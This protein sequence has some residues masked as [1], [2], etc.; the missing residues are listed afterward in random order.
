P[1]AAKAPTRP[2]RALGAPQTTC[3]GAPEPV[4]T[5]RTRSLSASGCFSA[6][7]TLAMTKGFSAALS[8]TDSTSRP[9][10][11]SRSTISSSVA[12]VSRCSF[13]QERVNFMCLF[14]AARSVAQSAE[15]GR[16]VERAE[17]VML[18]PAHIGVEEGAQVRH[19]VFQHGDAVDAHAP[20]EALILV[21][22]EPA[23]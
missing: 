13:S 14:L 21:R 8:S 18:E 15:Q 12:S 4:S 7:R 19:A 3:M 2:A 17:T 6:V 10:A 20:G 16:Q 11:V 23:G 22:I 5:D 9:M 1:G